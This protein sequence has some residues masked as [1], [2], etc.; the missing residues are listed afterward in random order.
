MD[1]EKL[2]NSNRY[3][4]TLTTDCVIT[5]AC[6]ITYCNGACRGFNNKEKLVYL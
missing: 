3:K 1:L 6:S 5:T 2:N 4:R